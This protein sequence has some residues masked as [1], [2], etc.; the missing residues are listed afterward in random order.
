VVVDEAIANIWGKLLADAD[1]AWRPMRAMDGFSAA[2]ASVHQK[3]LVTRNEM[4]FA[5]ADTR[6]FNPWSE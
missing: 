1:E 5:A 2:T 6:T 4:D 3:T